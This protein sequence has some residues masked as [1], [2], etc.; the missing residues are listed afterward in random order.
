MSRL[1]SVDSLL[2][3]DGVNF[4]GQSP[5]ELPD[6]SGLHD[7]EQ[8][9]DMWMNQFGKEP[10]KKTLSSSAA[11]S[12]P[13]SGTSFCAPVKKY[14]TQGRLE[15][16][17]YSFSIG[18]SANINIGENMD[19]DNDDD[20][21]SPSD[22]YSMKTKHGSSWVKR[23]S[24][25]N[26]GAQQQLKTVTVKATIS[27]VSVDDA[28][29]SFDNTTEQDSHDSGITSF[30]THTNISMAIPT[31]QSDHDELNDPCNGNE[32]SK[33][34]RQGPTVLPKPKKPLDKKSWTA[35]L[36][37]S[38]TQKIPEH[39]SQQNL[40][41]QRSSSSSEETRTSS[42]VGIKTSVKEIRERFQQVDEAK[43][44]ATEKFV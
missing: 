34:P 42:P 18:N 26:T 2:S 20:V 8:D 13:L 43:N 16:T 23:D 22:D 33:S 40:V 17:T 12:S 30:E 11:E 38:R 36:I 1:S 7:D 35:D 44:N 31:L 29:G 25:D 19:N 9:D 32:L 15:T 24:K 37:K 14:S 6:S 3:G 27:P 21:T 10:L 4:D 41:K 5:V 39:T 28:T